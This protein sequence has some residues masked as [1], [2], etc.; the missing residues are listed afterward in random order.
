MAVKACKFGGSSLADAAMQAKVK[1][2]VSADPA[3]RF[4]VPSAPGK[5][6]KEDQKITDLLYLCH[7]HAKQSLPF[8]EV[9]A[10]IVDRYWQIV[11]DLGIEVDLAPHFE[12]I[13]QD[14]AGG[15]SP[16][17]AA[18]RGEYLNG[19]IIS[20]LLDFPF[21]D[22]GEIIF[23]D[24]RGSL[25]AE[26]TQQAISK[27]LGAMDCAVVPGFYGT[28]INGKVK[29][30]SRGG[31]D[32][33]GAL[34]ARGVHASV[35]E[36]WTDVSGLLMGD[37]RIIDSPRPIA[38]LTYRELRELA[39]MGAT[40]L[41][42]E[43]IF[44]V[45]TAGIPVNVRN[46][47]APEEPG[48][49]ILSNDA[50][51][52]RTADISITGIAGRKDFTVIA[53]EKSLMNSELG[54]GR[55]LLG[56]LESNGISYEHSPSGIDTMSVVVSDDSLEDKVDRVIEEIQRVCQPDT[57]DVYP[58]MALIATV[59]RGMAYTPG[60]AARLFSG[61]ARAGVNIRMIDQGSSEINII[62]GVE[63]ADFEKA[64]RAIYD[65]FVEN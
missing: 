42:D 38:E 20:K 48:T 53:L 50:L 19:L 11:A 62:V 17:Y 43:A 1:A 61:L 6:H 44:P 45:R 55:R 41:H 15:E 16:D 10:L 13:K 58:H 26:R 40:V 34:V 22:A 5:R 60:T 37:P 35:Y 63:T 28:D 14:I 33:T 64:I 52:D 39:Y 3:R 36:N 2:I 12:K 30:F 8:D 4:I 18:S 7:A 65:A 57:I 21:V 46:T 23:F 47:N 49:M 51:P 32:I 59:G 24:K 27:K 31:S 54:F 25:D 56:V 29:T 9:Y